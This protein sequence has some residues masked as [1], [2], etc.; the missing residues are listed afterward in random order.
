MRRSDLPATR[1]GGVGTSVP[2]HLVVAHGWRGPIGSMG[3]D[4]P[5][6]LLGG[7]RALTPS[8][9]AS[10][11]GM[12]HMAAFRSA[13]AFACRDQAAAGSD[14]FRQ[15]PVALVGPPGTGR[16]LAARWLARGADMPLIRLDARWVAERSGE[17]RWPSEH[18]MPPA[19]VIAMAASGCANPIILLEVDEGFSDAASTRL[20]TMMDDRLNRRWLDEDLDLIL[21]LSQVT[22]IVQSTLLPPPLASTIGRCGTVIEVAHPKGMGSK[23]RNLSIAEEERASGGLAAEKVL[24]VFMGLEEAVDRIGYQ[25]PV[26]CSELCTLARGL[27]RAGTGA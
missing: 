6:P 22:W 24:S 16:G 8:G 15:R 18:R 20:A 27:S 5:L 14:F 3:L 17:G 19:P 2:P 13:V 1:T 9:L 4:R 12:E 21:D 11:P 26:A 7:G 23:L 10:A 25:G